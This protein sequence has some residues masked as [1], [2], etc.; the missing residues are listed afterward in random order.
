MVKLDCPKCLEPL[1]FA[2]ERRG[3]DVRCPNCQVLLRLPAKPLAAAKPVPPA[4]P[5]KPAKP[6]KP[7]PPPPDDD[8]IED[9]EVVRRPRKARKKR[10][11]SHTGGSSEM[12]EWLVPL[13]LFACAVVMNAMIA[14]RRGED[15]TGLLV[16]S[17]INL[18]VTVP[19]TI[20][21]MFVAAAALGVNFGGLFTAALKVAAI[22][23]VVQCIYLVGMSG[24]GDGSAAIV[25]LLAAPVYWGM[26][27]WLFDLTFVEALQATFLIGLVQKGVN[28]VVNLLAAGILLKAASVP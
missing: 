2:D 28:V 5:S 4:R 17:L 27:S 12:P 11:R 20:G 13:G 6:A 26:F 7:K 9:V 16:F 24:G 21:G 25:L 23:A 14:L 10:R 15:G 22:A 19:A 18:A 8:V 3:D 1:T